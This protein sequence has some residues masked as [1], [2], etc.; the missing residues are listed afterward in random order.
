MFPSRGIQFSDWGGGPSRTA[1]THLK[2]LLLVW[3]SQNPNGVKPASVLQ[4][5]QPIWA[6]MFIYPESF[7]KTWVDSFWRVQLVCFYNI[8]YSLP[9]HFWFGA[10]PSNWNVEIIIGEVVRRLFLAG[11]SR[12]SRGRV[13]LERL[14]AQQSRA[15][16]AGPGRNP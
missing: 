6:F 4:L 5:L 12:S 15:P 13:V 11:N 3:A 16:G 14:P 9:L 10:K 7:L 1:T 2:D 8:H